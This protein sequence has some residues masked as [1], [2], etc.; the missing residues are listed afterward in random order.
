MQ[1]LGVPYPLQ[2]SII[3]YPRGRL[4]ARIVVKKYVSLIILKNFQIFIFVPKISRNPKV[5]RKVIS[6]TPTMSGSITG[7]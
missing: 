6:L 2:E 1:K 3:F 7:T 4:L 5:A